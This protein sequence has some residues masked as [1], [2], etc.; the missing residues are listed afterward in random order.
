MAWHIKSMP[1]AILF[2]L[3]IALSEI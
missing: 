1:V 2:A 3:M